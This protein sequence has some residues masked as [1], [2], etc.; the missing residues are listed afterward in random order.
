[1]ELNFNN[2]NWAA[3]LVCL[4]IGQVFLTVWFTALFGKPWAKAY[5]VDDPKQHTKEVPGYT[6]AIQIISTALLVT[7][8]AALQGSLAIN[9]VGSGLMFGLYIALFFS[10]ATALPGYAFLKRWNAFFLAMGSQ[11]VLIIIISIILAIWK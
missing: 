10:I 5:G 4:V 6:Y 9:T 11:T 3:V 8:M 7:G 2:I 1:M